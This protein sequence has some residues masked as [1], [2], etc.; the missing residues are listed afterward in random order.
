MLLGR[1]FPPPI[2]FFGYAA[3]EDDI[4]EGEECLVFTLSVNETA[5][6][7]RDQGQVDISSDVALVRIE[8]LIGENSNFISH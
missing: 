8:D 4:I 3:A 2:P 1:F 6:D 5:L 7:P